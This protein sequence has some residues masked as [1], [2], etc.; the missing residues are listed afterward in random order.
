MAEPQTPIEIMLSKLSQLLGTI[1]GKLRN[2]L[3]KSGGTIDY[4]T[5]TNRLSATADYAHA[6]K[7]ARLFSLVGDASGHVSFNGSSDVEITVSIAELA[8]KADKSLTYSKDEV[9]QLFN[10]LIGLAPEEL[11]TVY[12]LAAALKGNQNSIGTIITELAKK[13]DSSSVYDK[14]AADARYLTKGAKAADSAMFDGKNSAAYAKQA[15]LDSTNQE[16]SSLITQLTAA[17]DNGTNL[18]NGV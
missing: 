11:D 9:N 5:V 17:F 14:V 2:K 18:I 3:N 13:V 12:E 7:V 4:L 10:N 8:N 16:L 1:D 6:L 15:G